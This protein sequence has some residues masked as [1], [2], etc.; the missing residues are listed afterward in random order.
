[1][2][3]IMERRADQQPV[4]N[5]PWPV[6]V[7]FVLGPIAAI[8][9]FLVYFVT[10]QQRDAAARTLEVL[11]RIEQKLDQHIDTTQD[12]KGALDKLGAE[13]HD[14]G[15]RIENYLRQLCVSN[16]Q[17]MQDRRDCLNVR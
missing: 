3:S 4:P 1:M 11:P 14:H 9:L 10:L 15:G 5:E 16:A 2:V 8:A 13:Q 6:R 12:I 17:T 7:I